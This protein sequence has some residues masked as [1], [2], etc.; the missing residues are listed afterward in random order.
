MKYVR[1]EAGMEEPENVLESHA[2]YILPSEV[3]VADDRGER[4]VTDES[5]VTK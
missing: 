5:G 4:V 1:L 2:A 3:W